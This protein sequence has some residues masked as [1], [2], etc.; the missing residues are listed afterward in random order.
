VDSLPARAEARDLWL[1][2]VRETA[3]A[4]RARPATRAPNP[5]AWLVGRLPR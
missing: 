1:P 5:P 4:G 3:A 2:G